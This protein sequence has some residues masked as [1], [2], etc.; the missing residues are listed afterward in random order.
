M[1]EAPGN[2]AQ[3]YAH[4]AHE[5]GF[6]LDEAQQH[7]VDCLQ[8]LHDD[9]KVERPAGWLGKFLAGRKSVRGLYLWGGVGRGKS[10][11]LD[12]F[13]ACAPVERKR[14]IH[15]HR[16]MQEVHAEQQTLKGVADPLVR[17]ARR[18][19]R[20]ARLLCF[21][22]FHVGDI[23]DAMLLGRLL[24][25]MLDQG[26]VLVATSNSAPDDLYQN[27]LQRSQFLPAIALIKDR[28]DIIK[29]DGGSDYRLRALEKVE[30]Y[31]FPLDAEA[32]DN[33]ESAYFR[34]A[35]GGGR[36]AAALEIEGRRILARHLA[37]GVVWFDFYEICGGPRG[38]ADYIEIARRFHT[39]LIS[40]IP[41]M[42]PEQAAEARRF[43]WLVDEFYD[44]K[45]K[46]IVSAQAP[47]HAL[48]QSGQNAEEFARTVSRLTE[49]QTKQ[50]LAQPHLP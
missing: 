7:A 47:P 43:T 48:Y 27:G 15:F 8:R 38:Q 24:R 19:A 49:M 6:S 36:G 14:R 9:L 33:L 45:V 25:E 46:L 22:E 44:R 11:L 3:W 20:E 16:F 42:E 32:E 40:G 13:F 4:H 29:V 21:D 34:L 30:I 50:Y 5:Q 2:L 18:L 39:V 31:H 41:C 37:P 28:L 23:A 26:V 10:F 35:G 1:K 12:G 17:V